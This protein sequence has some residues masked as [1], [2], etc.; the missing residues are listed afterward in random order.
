MTRLVAVTGATGF[1][2]RHL[3]RSFLDAGWRVRVLTRRDPIDPAWRP[4]AVEAVPG[5]LDDA[6]ALHGL[7]SGADA[8][9][10]I[11]ARAEGLVAGSEH[12]AYLI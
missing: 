11:P 4:H 3:V 6:G 9:V 10:R 1:L 2:G 12:D 5:D 8:V 7:V